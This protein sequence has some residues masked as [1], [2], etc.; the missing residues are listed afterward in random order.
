[1]TDK[2]IK[3]YGLEKQDAAS[4]A[5]RKLQKMG[6]AINENEIENNAFLYFRAGYMAALETLK[7]EKSLKASRKNGVLIM[8][9]FI[10]QD[11]DYSRIFMKGV[12]HDAEGKKAVVTDGRYCLISNL[13]NPDYAGKI[14]DENGLEIDGRFP[15]YIKVYSNGDFSNLVEDAIDIDS[16]IKIDKM[17]NITGKKKIAAFENGIEIMPGIVVGLSMLKTIVKYLKTQKEV[18]CYR[19]KDITKS[20]ELWGDDGSCLV[21]MPYRN[22]KIVVVFDKE[23]QELEE[24]FYKA[25]PDNLNGVFANKDLLEDPDFDVYK[26]LYILKFK[27]EQDYNDF[28][29]NAMQEG[30]SDKPI[31]DVIE[32]ASSGME[33]DKAVIVAA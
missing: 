13:Y 9:D 33:V 15:N 20:I 18:K 32:S 2:T 1:M 26:N 6:Y 7:I 19:H 30:T 12:Y 4:I 16:I 10:N 14:I 5:F 22:R 24:V 27:N 21:F 31:V 8:A 17:L 28:Y 23:N 3:N 11:L 25:I 29:D